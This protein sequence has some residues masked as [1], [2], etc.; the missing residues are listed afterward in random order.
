MATRDAARFLGIADEVGT[1][2]PG[3]RADLVL[4]DQSPMDDVTHLRQPSGVMVGGTW[5][6]RSALDDRLRAIQAAGG[7]Q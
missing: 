1:I 3:K 5:V 2:E 7:L 4:L 6:P